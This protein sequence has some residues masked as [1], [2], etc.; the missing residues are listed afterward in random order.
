MSEH[1]TWQ[2][3]P[4]PIPPEPAAVT[5]VRER[6]AGRAA[7]Q[8]VTSTPTQDAHYRDLRA[9]IDHIDHLA[10]ILA[11]VDGQVRAAT[12]RA[13]RTADGLDRLPAGTLLLDGAGQPW[14]ACGGFF[15]QVR[16]VPDHLNS[17]YL[18]AEI[19]S[20]GPWVVLYD[21]TSPPALRDV[22]CR[23]DLEGLGDLAVVLDAAGHAWQKETLAHAQADAYL[24]A[25]DVRAGWWSMGEWETTGTLWAR[26]GPLTLIHPGQDPEEDE[27][28]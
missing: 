26:R 8:A 4:A 15:Q 19:L 24:R 16:G 20:R 2:V 1:I 9:L 12:A 13:T 28:A 14:R 23:A 21:P 22:S 17:G 25:R 6:L 3:D 11:G 10:G 7:R 5:D 27:T 18:A